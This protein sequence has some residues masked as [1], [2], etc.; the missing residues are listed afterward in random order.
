MSTD[1]RPERREVVERATSAPRAR[2][3]LVVVS[4]DARDRYEHVQRVFANDNR[5]TVILDRRLG[6]R[7]QTPGARDPE[8]RRADRRSRSAIEDGLRR[9]GWAIVRLEAPRE[10]AVEPSSRMGMGILVVDDDPLVAG[11]LEDILKSDG[12]RV[13]TARN[14]VE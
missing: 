1:P 5:V 13:T 6:E 3:L 11:L 7:R 4:R 8:R 2:G 10:P 9:Q 12:H 14:G